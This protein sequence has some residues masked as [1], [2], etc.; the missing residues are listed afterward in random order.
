MINNL[1]RYKPF[2]AAL[3]LTAAFHVAILLFVFLP[4][5]LGGYNDFA[6]LY[7][8]GKMVV[9]GDAENLYNPDKQWEYQQREFQVPI[10]QGPLLFNHAPHEALIFALFASLPF[11][12][13][14]WAWAT[15]NIAMFL[16][17]GYLLRAYLAMLLPHWAW[18]PIIGIAWGPALLCLIQG[19]DSILILFLYVAAFWFWKRNHLMLTGVFLS[20]VL[21]KPQL[22]LPFVVILILRRE[23]RVIAGFASGTAVLAL[24]SGA[25]VGYK[26]ILGYVTFL[27]YFDRLPALQSAAAPANM[28][29]L[30][31]LLVTSLSGPVS[32]RA[33]PVIVVLASGLVVIAAA[34][35]PKPA[36]EETYSAG[37]IA[38]LL[39]SYHL[40]SYDVT[41][42]LLPVILSFGHWPK[43][44]QRWPQ[45]LIFL[46]SV[47]PWFVF[48][49]LMTA[50]IYHEANLLAL[51]LLG[52]GV[53]IWWQ[54]RIAPLVLSN[55]VP[56]NVE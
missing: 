4:Y 1:S 44:S 20:A 46:C 3:L 48:D 9:H 11:R 28:P 7:T 45:T 49:V 10:R 16:A 29:N 30:R 43:F 14:F 47:L 6:M 12:A 34:R 32:A 13:A 21:I 19:Q 17:I 56:E 26:T 52:F 24:A 54:T 51:L 5:S 18:F 53:M 42:L 38:T 39:A 15:V 36:V 55:R 27:R 50:T 37:I 40:Y 25:V 8:A 33:L 31:G 22:V 2:K 41:L 35:L 23:W